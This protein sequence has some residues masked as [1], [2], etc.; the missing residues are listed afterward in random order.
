[1]KKIL[2]LLAA[3]ITTLSIQAQQLKESEVP[4]NLKEAFKKNHRDAKKI[5]W[6]KEK[7]GNFEATYEQEEKE[8]S[9]LLNKD[10]IVLETEV[11]I[12]ITELPVSAKDYVAK[13]YKEAKIKEAAKI[14]DAKGLVTYEAEIKGM[15]VIFDSHGKFIKELKD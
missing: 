5:K 4:A 1:M 10:G 8:Q 9:V 6:E 7:D 13:N 14:T 11:E 15:D 12:A 2:V 3:I